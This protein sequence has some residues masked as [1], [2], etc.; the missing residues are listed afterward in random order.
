[1]NLSPNFEYMIKKMLLI[2]VL[3]LVMQCAGRSDMS[4]QKHPP[5]WIIAGNVDHVTEKRLLP[6]FDSLSELQMIREQHRQGNQAFIYRLD[7]GGDIFYYWLEK[8]DSVS[9]KI[10]NPDSNKP[11]GRMWGIMTAD[12]QQGYVKIIADSGGLMD[13]E[14]KTV[15]LF[16]DYVIMRS[17]VITP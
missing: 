13:R 7:S 14:T 10:D 11:D 6:R 16:A 15:T 3:P 1:M 5:E 8:G 17:E 9:I 12:E 2:L 4:L